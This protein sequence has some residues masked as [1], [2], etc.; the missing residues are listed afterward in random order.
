MLDMFT[1][2]QLL[3]SCQDL[4]N[5]TGTFLSLEPVT[6]H[7]Q[8]FSLYFVLSFPFKDRLINTEP[9]ITMTVMDNIKGL[10]LFPQNLAEVSSPT[11]AGAGTHAR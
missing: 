11:S 6:F 5:S 4:V 9:G 10:S 8:Q 2:L 7:L 1:S 3:S